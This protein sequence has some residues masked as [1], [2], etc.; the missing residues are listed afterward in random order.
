MKYTRTH[1]LKS[2]AATTAL[3]PFGTSQAEA[4]IPAKDLKLG[5]AS[6]SLREYS[7]DDLIKYCNKLNLNYVSLKSFHLP[8]NAS[9]ET[10]QEVATKIRAAGIDL[11]GAGVI[12]MK[13]PDEVKT[14][15]GYAKT[16]GLK[17]IIGVPNHELLPLVE[18]KVRETGVML[19]IHNH[20]P[21]DLVYPTPD[22][23]YE[24]IKNLDRRIGLCIDIGH[25]IRLGRDPLKAL[26]RY[27]DR[28]YDMHLKDIDKA[29]DTGASTEMGHG[30]IDIPKVLKTLQAINYQ[31]VMSIEYEK[32]GKNA[33]VGLS[34]SV[35][36]V[37]GL[38]K[39]MK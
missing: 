37:R 32:D 26:V 25:E 3:L 17:M 16:A 21:G 29:I 12:Y 31:G 18:Q 30:V 39:L 4:K 1:F 27:K 10:I 19:A 8:L 20:G 15:F 22:T 9:I 7:L 14:A 6:Y 34:E 35:G 28:L 13:T 5:L 33:I 23:V 24:H 11:Y 38:M 2:L 36:Y